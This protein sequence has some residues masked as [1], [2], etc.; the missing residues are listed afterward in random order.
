MNLDINNDL[1][2]KATAITLLCVSPFSILGTLFI[3]ILYY[4]YP[5]IR[6]FAFTLVAHL[7]VSCLLFNIGLILNA[8]TFS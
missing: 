5:H 3:I 6:N 2:Y 1:N 7:N 8:I 4:A